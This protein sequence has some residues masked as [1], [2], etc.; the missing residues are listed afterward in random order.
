MEIE[1]LV[2]SEEI[3]YPL[4]SLSHNKSR[5]ISSIKDLTDT[6]SCFVAH[7]TR[8]PMGL[9]PEYYDFL[10]RYAFINGN[11]RFEY[12]EA[13]SREDFA[14]FEF[15]LNVLTSGIIV[16]REQLSAYE[17]QFCSV[18]CLMVGCYAFCSNESSISVPHFSVKEYERNAN[19]LL[20]EWVKIIRDSCFIEHKKRNS[21]KFR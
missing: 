8:I 12:L 17:L 9:V 6:Y 10:M 5:L 1:Y 19:I 7:L 14:T 3:T 20:R 13:R 11:F 21:L 16:S 15:V 2:N 18:Q 4:V